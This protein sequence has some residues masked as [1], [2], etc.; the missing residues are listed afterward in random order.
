M[1]VL[2][3]LGIMKNWIYET[4]ISCFNGDTPHAA[5]FGIKLTD[6][7]KVQLEIYKGSNTLASLLSTGEFAIN[8]INSTAYFYDSIYEMENISFTEAKRVNAPVIKDCPAYIEARVTGNEE[9]KQS[10]IIEAEIISIT[11]NKTPVLFNRAE[12]LLMESLIIATRI[13]YSAEGEAEKR[14]KENYRVIKKV[15]PDSQYA[16]IM[17][18]LLIRCSILIQ[19]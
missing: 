2:A 11:M 15:A 7:N 12:G 6:M 3:D 13:K 5:P 1:S 8:F 14:L 10:Y 9:K 18:K 17:E 16:D 19:D 4:I